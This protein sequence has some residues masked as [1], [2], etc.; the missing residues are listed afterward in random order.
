LFGGGCM[1]LV[2]AVGG[3][4][5]LGL[6]AGACSSGEGPLPSE[7]VESTTQ[8]ITAACNSQT[9]GLPCDPDGPSGALFE[10]QGVCTLNSSGTAQCVGL[11]AAGLANMDG[12]VCGTSAGT[13]DAACALH[14]LGKTCL[15][16]NAAVG[17]ACRP[18]AADSPCDGQCNG[19][20]KCTP[21]ANACAFGR[22]ADLCTF[23]TC[24]LVAAKTCTTQNLVATTTCSNSSACQIGACNATGV[25]VTG[26]QKGCDDGNSCT[27]DSC[28]LQTGGCIGTPNNANKC[29]DGNACTTG[30]SCN[31]G[32]CKPGAV[33]LNCDDTNACTTDSC[34]P[35]TGC[36]H[37][38]KNCNDNNA[39]TVD[40]CAPVNG[41]CGHAA[42][43]CDD[44]NPC[45]DDSCDVTAGCQ[46]K[47]KNC[48]DN[49]A[50]TVDACVAGQ[51]THAT[52]PGC[53]AGGAGGG[54]GAAGT[55]GT[56]SGGA[57]GKAGNGGG[58]A[59]GAG[60]K[61]G[62]SGGGAGGVS[63]AGA[64]GVG[65]VTAGGGGVGGVA[66][67]GGVGEAG[68]VSGGNSGDAGSTSGGQSG[69]SGGS[70]STGGAS[71]GGS[72]AGS[73]GAVSVAGTGGSDIGGSSDIGVGGAIDIGTGKPSS[74]DSG[75]C[76]CHT[77]PSSS[78]RGAFSLGFLALALAA[79]RRRRRHVA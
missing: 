64:G 23:K 13:G 43:N 16:Q 72:S 73:S 52:T 5:F 67:G 38:Q 44:G 74:K 1:R 19:A 62:S 46:H 66:A 20:G 30:D 50:C 60:G 79:M 68:A 54:G 3:L 37:T 7:S 18:T 17:A 56:T 58:G 10:C 26:G 76:G 34:D 15:A 25:C 55:G 9:I 28:N 42:L 33:P 35:A 2:S 71:A 12:K 6:L 36:F 41:V 51:C 29:T 11:A 4:V 31:G 75:G 21:I 47:A 61:A 40:T 45:T 69:A 49:N 53:G 14:C 32:I 59:G 22:D 48:N 63:S 78:Q 39:C 57:G 24:N 65:G 70:L 77:A 27:D 8:A